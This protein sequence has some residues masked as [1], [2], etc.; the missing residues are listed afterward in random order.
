MSEGEPT[1]AVTSPAAVI[2]A[3]LL[4]AAVIVAA[5]AI[6]ASDSGDADVPP[7]SQPVETGLPVGTSVS[8]GR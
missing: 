8:A 5:L 4:L 6:Q 1:A 3:V 2:A 7:P